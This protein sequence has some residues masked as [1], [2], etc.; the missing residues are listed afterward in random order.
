MAVGTGRG[1]WTWASGR[2]REPVEDEEF[3]FKIGATDF[4]A[5]GTRAI[6]DLRRAVDTTAGWSIV[7]NNFGT[8]LSMSARRPKSLAL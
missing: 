2:L 5:A 7:P 6:E 4:V 3:R 8:S 1:Q